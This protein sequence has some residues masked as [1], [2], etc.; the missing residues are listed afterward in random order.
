MQKITGAVFLLIG[1]A[2]LIGGR[3]LADQFGSQ[4]EPIFNGAPTDRAVYIYAC[5][6]VIALL[7]VVQFFWNRK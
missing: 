5:G 7:G 3:K 2:A 4:V 6:L 1:L